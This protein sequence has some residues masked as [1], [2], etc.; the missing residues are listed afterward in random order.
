M[1]LT[2]NVPVMPDFIHHLR[3]NWPLTLI[4]VGLAIYLPVISIRGV[5]FTNQ[6]SIQRSREP[7][8]FRSWV[9]V[10][11]V[12]LLVAAAALVGTYFLDPS[13]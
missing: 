9:R 7:D 3:H 13:K 5:V 2:A 6:G 10:F 12:L 8:R 11:V 1:A 4:V